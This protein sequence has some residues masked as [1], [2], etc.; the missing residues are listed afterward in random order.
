MNCPNCGSLVSQDGCHPASPRV[1]C[2]RKCSEA[3]ERLRA[4]IRAGLSAYGR[5]AGEPKTCTQ[6]GET[7][8]YNKFVIGAKRADG[9]SVRKHF[10]YACEYLVRKGK[11]VIR[12]KFTDVRHPMPVPDGFVACKVCLTPHNRPGSDGGAPFSPYCSIYCTDRAGRRRL[13][14]R[15]YGLTEEDYWN[16]LAEQNS[17]CP[18]CGSTLAGY[19]LG[20]IHIDHIELGGRKIV[21]GLLCGP[22]NPKLGHVEKA[23]A[24]GWVIPTPKLIAYL[25]RGRRLQVVA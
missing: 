4:R 18:L 10:C 7:K 1:Y 12:R 6:C 9:S 23:I 21:R 14:I 13:R 15:H 19:G 3:Q 5:R 17:Q 11:D 20:S 22:C 16:L 24:L 25:D 8:P 2:S